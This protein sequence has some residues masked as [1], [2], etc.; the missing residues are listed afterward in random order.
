M[1]VRRDRALCLRRYPWSESSLVVHALTP[2]HGRLHLVARGAFRPTSRFYA[3]VDLF[4]TLELEWS[5]TAGRELAELRSG[6][7]VRRR[8]RI[9]RDLERYRAA[10]TVLELTDLAARF[11]PAD[12]ASFHAAE[13]AL[14]DLE[15]SPEDPAQRLAR[16]ELGYLREMGVFP[17]LESC[18]AC[19]GPAPALPPARTRAA[20]SAGAGGRLCSRCAE[21][22]RLSGRRVGTLPCSVLDDARALA[23]GAVPPVLQTTRIEAVRDFVGRFLGYHLE[24]QPRAHRAFLATANRNAPKGS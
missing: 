5:Q 9:P 19:G 11:G 20:F 21:E 8:T 16:F 18:A 1:P 7:I 14:E 6:S 10:L 3:V 23:D 2:A 12:P 4:D 15:A 22:A 17:A 13:A 24:S